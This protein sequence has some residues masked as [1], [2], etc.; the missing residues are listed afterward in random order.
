MCAGQGFTV[1]TAAG[2]EGSLELLAL[3]AVRVGRTDSP[4]ASTSGRAEAPQLSA[5]HDAQLSADLGRL[6]SVR[7]TARGSDVA[8]F[9]TAALQA[10]SSQAHAAA[11]HTLALRAALAATQGALRT[12]SQ[13]WQAP[14]KMLHAACKS[15]RGSFD[16][17]DPFSETADVLRQALVGGVPEA[18]FREW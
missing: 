5:R 7:S 9:S 4:L 13:A 18:T 1:L 16:P 6:V 14:R 8:V 2:A 10:L 15:I 17:G 11:A 3:G 12:V